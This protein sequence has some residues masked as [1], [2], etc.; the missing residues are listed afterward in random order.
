MARKFDIPV[1][2][3]SSIISRMKSARSAFD[4][5]KKDRGPTVLDLGPVRF[6]LARH[7]GFCFGVENAIEIAYRA[8]EENPSKRVYLLSEMIHNPQ[9]NADLK[10]RGVRFLMST[11]GEALIPFE[12]LKPDDIVIVPAFGTTKELF[13]RIEQAGINPK[14]YD[15]TCPF[16]ERVW[17][18]A[19]ELGKKG[20]A[21]I[22]H[23]KHSHEETRA[24]FSHSQL[25]GPSLVIRDIEE[26]KTLAAYIRQEKDSSFFKSDFAD[27][28]SPDFCAV[29]SL[30]R[31][32][33]VNQTTMLASETQEITDLLKDALRERF[34]V[35]KLKEHFADT[36][37]TL[38]YATNE[39]QDAV[40][41]L[42][43]SGGDI[44]VVV[45]GY[46]SSNT[47]HLVELCSPH[48][49][50]FYIKDA[51][52]I[53]GADRINHLDLDSGEV[54]QTKDWL[55]LNRSRLDILLTAG[56]SC[57]DVVVDQ[58]LSRL[59]ALFESDDFNSSL[60]IEN[61]LSSFES[62]SP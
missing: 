2:Y 62:A 39:N 34:G 20:F 59:A 43:K 40:H 31:F 56:A 21:I 13:D 3:Q 50:T 12:E 52:E 36:R 23:G 17:K 55:P 48:M 22:I 38:C 26:A 45:G 15:A 44:A 58:V 25:S 1:I 9:V 10:A 6:K 32:G 28:Y 29:D 19:G 51:D 47:S 27:R 35:D 5:R 54:I 37:D 18:R 57:P 14:R 33:V 42:V 4:P 7:F 41:S 49:P 61:A 8:I 11:K 46:N 16:V 53:I 60:K 30:K 24:T